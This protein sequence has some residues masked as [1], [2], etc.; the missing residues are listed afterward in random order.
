ML[1]VL[2]FVLAFLGVLQME[3]FAFGFAF[4]VVDARERSDVEHRERFAVIGERFGN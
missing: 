4:W 1:P 2:A 3:P